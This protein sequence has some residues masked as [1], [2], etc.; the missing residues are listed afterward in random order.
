MNKAKNLLLMIG[1]AYLALIGLESIVGFFCH[2]PGVLDDNDLTFLLF[3]ELYPSLLHLALLP[4]PVVLLWQNLKNRSGKVLPIATIVVHSVLL[5]LLLWVMV[6][7]SI[8]QYLVLS[9]L[10]LTDTFFTIVLFFL[11]EGGFSLLVGYLLT[12]ISSVLSLPKRNQ[13]EDDS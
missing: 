11:G 2:L 1:I 4:L 10:G 8:P 12:V 9:K 7:P 5:L 3:N 13:K 6:T